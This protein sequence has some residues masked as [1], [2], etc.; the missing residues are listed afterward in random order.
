MKLDGEGSTGGGLCIMYVRCELC[1][2][3][4]GNTNFCCSMRNGLGVAIVVVMERGGK[5]CLIGVVNSE[6]NSQSNV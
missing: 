2:T 4:S 5:Y 3:D 1:V 6:V